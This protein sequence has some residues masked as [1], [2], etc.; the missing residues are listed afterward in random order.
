MYTPLHVLRSAGEKSNK[1]LPPRILVDFEMEPLTCKH[2]SPSTGYVTAENIC[3]EE[4]LLETRVEES[5][6]LQLERVGRIKVSRIT[7]FP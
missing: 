2:T 3:N 7:I 1:E 6:A 4:N 5:N